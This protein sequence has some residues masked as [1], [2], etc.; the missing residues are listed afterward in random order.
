MVGITTVNSQLMINNNIT[1]TNYA[2]IQTQEKSM[3]MKQV[4]CKIFNCY[5]I[6]QNHMA[7]KIFCNAHVGTEAILFQMNIKELKIELVTP[8][9]AIKQVLVLHLWYEQMLFKII[10]N[11]PG[12]IIAQIQKSIHCLSSKQTKI[13]QSPSTN[14]NHYIREHPYLSFK[15]ILFMCTALCV[16]RIMQGAH[17][18]GVHTVKATEMKILK[19]PSVGK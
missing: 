6:P 15:M 8:Q 5:Q 3:Y 17:T 19:S 2:L 11:C 1:T 12:T 18:V 4:T 14:T 9:K 16:K 10:Y 13:Y 7:Q